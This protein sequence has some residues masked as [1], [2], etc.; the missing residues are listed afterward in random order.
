MG[1]FSYIAQIK[2]AVCERVGVLRGERGGQDLV[3]YGSVKI[4]DLGFAQIEKARWG[5]RSSPQL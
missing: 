2:W 5:L 4:I 3:D 1:N